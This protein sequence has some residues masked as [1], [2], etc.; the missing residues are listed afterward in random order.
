MTKT[1]EIVLAALCFGIWITGCGPSSSGATTSADV[2]QM[3]K[4]RGIDPA[5]GEAFLKQLAAVPAAQRP[6]FMQAHPDDARNV[7]QIQD[8]DFQKRFM[9]VVRSH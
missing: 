9:Q 4:Q 3:Y 7:A 2:K 5:K 6:Q 8:P 1:I